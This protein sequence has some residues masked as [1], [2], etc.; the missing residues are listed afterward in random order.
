[1]TQGRRPRIGL[2]LG[3]GGA[4][5][6]AHVGVLRALRDLGVWPDVVAGTSIGAMVG[7]FVAADA[8]EALERELEK[9]TRARLASF[10]I[11]AHL[12]R[13]GLFS[14][15]AVMRWLERPEL[16]GPCDFTDLARPF[17]AVATDLRTGRAVTLREGNVA[18]AV[19]ASISIPGLF[20][21]VPHGEGALI[22][23]GFSDP[24]PVAAARA[25]GADFVIAVDITGDPSESPIG[26]TPSLAATLVQ[27]A[28][29]VEHGLSRLTL[30]QSPADFLLTPATGD[31]QTLDFVGGRALVAAGETAVRDATA[32]LLEALGHALNP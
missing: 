4:R 15:Q 7:A 12:P 13:H 2:A 25:L 17:A 27:T 14:G 20:D 11:E 28:R 22:D 16:L 10:F 18:Q 31:V 9:L 8:F 30:A 23:G 1:M 29:L 26:R 32:P 21:P 6:W 3:S 24:V 19:R 5:G